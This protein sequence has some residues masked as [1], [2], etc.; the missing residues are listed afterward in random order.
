MMWI[1][2]ATVRFATSLTGRIA[3]ILALGT[4]LALVGALLIA[5]HARRADFRSVQNERVITSAVDVI[6]RLKRDPSHVLAGLRDDR[7][8][9]AHLIDGKIPPMG[10]VDA[11]LTSGIAA[12]VDNASLPTIAHVGNL[13]CRQTNGPWRR[14]RVAGFGTPPMPDCWLLRFYAE[15]RPI[16][17]AIYLPRLP[18]PPSW[19]TDPLFLLLVVVGAIVLSLIVARLA[20][21]PLRR[22]SSAANAFARSIDA[23][24]VIETGPSD[25]RAALAT[26]NVMQERVRA[27]V[28]ERT[29]MLATIGHDLQT[30]LTRLRLR[31]EHVEDKVLREHLVA[32]LSATLAMVKRGLDL[33]RSTDSAEEWSTVDLDSLLSSLADDA[34]EFGHS[35]RFVEGCGALVKV[36]LDALTRCLSNLVDNAIKYG[37]NA[38]IASRRV[39]KAVVVT[40][41][42]NGPGMTESLLARAF[43]PFVRGDA[44]RSSGDGSGIGL[45][46]ARAQAFAIGAEVSIAN[47]DGGGMEATVRLATSNNTKR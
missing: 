44:S 18:V 42:D 6:T 22:L 17:V 4:S 47:Q 31:L 8:L 10:R 46:I 28:R 16:A 34:A 12:S 14:S 29:R 24:P 40:V 2:T 3:L 39:G 20:T 37:G 11:E 43:D 26:F 32:D 21:A 36:R 7:L 41:R 23:D 1:V 25:V 27:G 30:P 38:D 15:G 33:A 35:V 13:I 19:T 5:E 45:T 9:G